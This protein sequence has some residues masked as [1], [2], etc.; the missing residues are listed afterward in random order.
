MRYREL[1]DDGSS[2]VL[3]PLSSQDPD[4]LTLGTAYQGHMN[5]ELPSFY[6]VGESTIYPSREADLDI[7]LLP[8]V[9][10][11]Q[12]YPSA[13]YTYG[14]LTNKW[15]RYIFGTTLTR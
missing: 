15:A 3:K 11:D 2:W 14:N 8:Y 4:E 12:E 5:S 10:T 9:N 7:A 13:E 1:S 6:V